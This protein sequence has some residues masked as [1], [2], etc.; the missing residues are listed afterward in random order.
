[1]SPEGLRGRAKAWFSSRRRTMFGPVID[2]VWSSQG[3]QLP[4]MSSSGVLVVLSCA[5][6]TLSVRCQGHRSM[7]DL[8]D[9]TAQWSGG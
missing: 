9:D 4:G 5:G 8:P 3:S 1:M 6:R 2:M 7:S